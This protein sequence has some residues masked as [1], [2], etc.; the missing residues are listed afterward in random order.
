MKYL[1]YSDKEWDW[2]ELESEKIWVLESPDDFNPFDLSIIQ[3]MFDD[4]SYP[5]LMEDLLYTNLS[6]DGSFMARS[7]INGWGD[8]LSFQQEERDVFLE[9]MKQNLNIRVLETVDLSNE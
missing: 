4:L 2:E 5:Y 8:I 6:Y 1:V 7:V 9:W 3:K